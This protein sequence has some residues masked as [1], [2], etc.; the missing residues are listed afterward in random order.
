MTG[1][2]SKIQNPKSKIAHV[3]LFLATTAFAISF[4]LWGLLSG[5]API[6]KAAYGLTATQTSLLVAIPVL[7][8]SVGRLPVGLLADRYGGRRVFSALLLFGLV[9]AL[10][11]ALDHSYPSLLFWGFWLG[12]MGTSF[13]VGVGFL[14]P[15]F[16]PQQQGTALGIYGAGNAGQS[17]A[18][19]GGPLLAAA[20]GVSATFPL[21]GL[22]SLAWGVVFALWARNAPRVAPPSTLAENVRVLRSEPLAWLLSL[23]YFLTFGGFVA[24]GVYLPS[25]LQDVF[26]LTPEDAGARTAGFVVLATLCR[27]LG[28]WIADRIGGE[29]LLGF[30]FP[31]VA[32]LAW[33]LSA[34]KSI[35]VFTVGA[36]GCAAFLGLGNGAVF[37][38]VP[39]FFPTQTGT[40]TGLV[41]AAGGLGGFFPPL[42]LG[43]FRDLVGGYVPGFFLLNMFALGCALLLQRVPA[44]LPSTTAQPGAS[45]EDGLRPEAP[46]AVEQRSGRGVTAMSV[47]GDPSGRSDLARLWT[48]TLSVWSRRCRHASLVARGVVELPS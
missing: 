39:R 44:S 4:A 30:V 8:G 32:A 35:Y 2:Q 34:N 37:K 15:W 5:L 42:L 10:A 40:V 14:S 3:N 31:V 13:A 18:V 21:F 7:F 43:F 19:F 11:L 38:L 29:R 36:L 48:R 47:E 20:L 23:F 16:P 12:A 25:L 28:G 6:F 27:P 33:L 22:A 9:P 46:S 1:P 41:G 45:A 24:L 26:E 17:V